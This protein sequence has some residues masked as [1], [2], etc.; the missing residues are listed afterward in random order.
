M[1]GTSAFCFVFACHSAEDDVFDFIFS[2]DEKNQ[3]I[4]LTVWLT[5]YW[6]NPYLKWD[7]HEYSGID[8]VHANNEY[9]WLP[10]VALYNE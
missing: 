9:F 3:A 10:D 8:S 7:P 2:Q 4:R 1:V 5:F 6:N